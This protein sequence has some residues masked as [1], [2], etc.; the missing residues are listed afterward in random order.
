MSTINGIGTKFLGECE[1]HAD[2]SYIATRWFT[3]VYLPVI[4][5]YSARILGI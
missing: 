2:G 5:L 3:F 4:P 1:H